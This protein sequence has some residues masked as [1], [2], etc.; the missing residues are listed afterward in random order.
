MGCCKYWTKIRPSCIQWSRS[1]LVLLIW[2]E[3]QTFHKEK[4]KQ[5]IFGFVILKKQQQK[6]KTVWDREWDL[7]VAVLTILQKE[8]CC[9]GFQGCLIKVPVPGSHTEAIY[10]NSDLLFGEG[11]GVQVHPQQVQRKECD[12]WTL[13]ACSGRVPDVTS[14]LAR[15]GGDVFTLFPWLRTWWWREFMML[16]EH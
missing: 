1:L 16:Q 10:S 8:V 15:Q 9:P 13:H 11:P 2:Q 5:K 3:Q 12:I 6:N 4:T 14:G 7:A